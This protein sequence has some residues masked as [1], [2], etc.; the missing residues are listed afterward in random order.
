MAWNEDWEDVRFAIRCRAGSRVS[1][2]GDFNAWNP[3]AH[4]II[5][6]GM[7]AGGRAWQLAC[8]GLWR[9]L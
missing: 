6:P 4:P 8:L 5:A 3:A 2:V 1:L 9:G 7:T